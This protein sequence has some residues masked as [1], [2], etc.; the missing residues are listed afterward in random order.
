M[1]DKESPIIVGIT[2]ASG[3]I[4]GHSLVKVLK[5]LAYCVYVVVTKPG[6][7]VSV[8]EN[9]VEGFDLADKLYEQ[10]DLFAPIASGSF[11]HQGMVIAPC[12]MGTLGKVA[13]GYGDNV[14]TRAADV[15]L[16]ERRKLIL[17]SRETPLSSIHLQN[18][19][20]LD[21][22]GATIL[23]ACPH[24][25]HNPKTITELVDTLLGR[26]LDHLNIPHNVGVRWQGKPDDK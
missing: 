2:G 20:K 9:Q 4:Y 19:L 1:P 5:D 12:S 25:Y 8:H 22:A 3:A 15:C 26:I 14:L 21:R 11:K 23:P 10:D 18:M 13:N 16:K 24:F 6:R 7:Q 17:V